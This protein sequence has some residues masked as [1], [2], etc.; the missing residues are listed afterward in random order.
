MFGGDTAKLHLTVE[1]GVHWIRYIILMHL[2]QAPTG[3]IKVFI[4][5]AQVDIS[6]QGW[7]GSEAFK[8]IR[9]VFWIFRAWIDRDRLLGLPH[10]IITTP[11][12]K[13]RAL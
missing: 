12:G 11:P 9:K 5:K 4:V 10:T 2:A 7:H 3:D 6:D 13:N 1:H 8:Q